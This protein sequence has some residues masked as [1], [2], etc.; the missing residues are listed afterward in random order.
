L[1]EYYQCDYEGC[2]KRWTSE[3]EG[4]TLSLSEETKTFCCLGCF[5]KFLSKK[6]NVEITRVHR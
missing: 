4:I 2:D 1:E 6:F 5:W 3:D